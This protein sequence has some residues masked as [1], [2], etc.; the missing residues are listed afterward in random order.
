MCV[1]F[2]YLPQRQAHANTSSYNH[3]IEIFMEFQKKTEQ[4]KAHQMLSHSNSYCTR[5][6]TVS[7]K[8]KGSA[9]H[10]VATAL[11]FHPS[12]LFIAAKVQRSHLQMWSSGSNLPRTNWPAFFIKWLAV[13]LK[14]LLR[15]KGHRVIIYRTDA[16]DEVTDKDI[17][18]IMQSK[19]EK[20]LQFIVYHCEVWFRDS[21][22]SALSSL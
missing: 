12:Y 7:G 5:D 4:T 16:R 6:T 13:L 10:Q 3:G 14:E 18:K 2:N 8:G 9:P 21:T 17:T 11:Q 1:S 15:P 20:F 19:D 22:S